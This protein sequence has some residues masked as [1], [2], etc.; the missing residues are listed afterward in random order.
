MSNASAV[1]RGLP[2]ERCRSAVSAPATRVIPFAS[3]ATGPAAVQAFG[4]LKSASARPSSR[5]LAANVL[6]A[7]V[8]ALLPM[9]GAAAQETDAVREPDPP[10]DTREADTAATQLDTIQVTGTRIRGGTTPSPV[11]AFGAERIKEEGFRDLG[12]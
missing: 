3:P 6:A 12:V 11:I 10:A 1:V 9:V 8:I 7:A 4:T 2:L 5:W